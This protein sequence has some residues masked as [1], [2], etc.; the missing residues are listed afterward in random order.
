MRE[1]ILLFLSILWYTLG[2]IVICGLVARLCRR[3]FMRMLSG[4]VGYYMVIGSGLIGTPVHELSHALMCLLFGHKIAEIKLWTPRSTDGTLGY[5]SHSWNK[6][7][8]YHILGNLFIGIGPILGGMGAL[9]LLLRLCF[10]GA[11]ET[12]TDAARSVVESGEPGILQGL[13][14]FGEGLRMFPDMVKEAMTDD[15]VPVWARLLGVI[16]LICVSLHIELSLADIKHSLKALPLYGVPV[17]LCTVICALL[18]EFAAVDAVGT[19]S[20]ALSLFSAYM[21]SLFVIVLVME[22]ALIVLA[23]PFFL[24]KLLISRRA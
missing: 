23:L 18:N 6:K 11:L 8:P 9:T 13:T 12:Y 21:T 2:I 17:L 24:I 3:L 20:H 14:L 7:N 1:Y 19:V 16:G 15:A 5:V 4:G 10:P 22:V